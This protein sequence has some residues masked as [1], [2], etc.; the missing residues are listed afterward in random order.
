[1]KDNDDFR[2]IVAHD[3]NYDK[4]TKQHT[5]KI[6]SNYSIGDVWILLKKAKSIIFL[7]VNFIFLKKN[8]NFAT[9]FG[10]PPYG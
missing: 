1:M 4:E 2:D 3:I 5:C 8:Y 7:S 9:A 10:S 6:E